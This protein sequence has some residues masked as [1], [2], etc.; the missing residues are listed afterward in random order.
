MEP[1]DFP[2][3]NVNM[4]PPP[5]LDESQCQR[6]RSFVGTVP[7]GHLEGARVIVVAWQPSPVDIARIIGGAP[8]FL[9]V[10][11]GLPPHSLTTT[12]QEAAHQI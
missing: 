7:R 11:G 9:S 5:D 1:T 2:E 3:A 10:L 8:V 6:I 4:N 12:F